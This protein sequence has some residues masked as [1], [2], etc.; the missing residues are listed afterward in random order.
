LDDLFYFHAMDKSS[1]SVLDG[2]DEKPTA[3]WF[4]SL[5]MY[6]LSFPLV[7]AGA[8]FKIQHWPF[9]N[10]LILIGG[11]VF[12]L[13]SVLIFFSRPR[14]V[15]EW[16]Y[17][18][19]QMS[20]VAFLILRFVFNYRDRLIVTIVLSLFAIGFLANLFNWPGNREATL[21]GEEEKEEDY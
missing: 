16:L 1:D 11:A 6:I 12:L 3:A 20:I 13:R 10:L 19:G 17:F 7:I 18:V 5:W 21:P 15:F 8:M 2:P 9:A 14:M 4:E